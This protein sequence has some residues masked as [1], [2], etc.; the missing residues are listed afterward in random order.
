MKVISSIECEVN[1][2]RLK[3]YEET[4][5]LTPAQYKKRLDKITESAAQEYGFKVVQSANGK[6]QET[7]S[8]EQESEH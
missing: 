7:Q 3:I 6:S 2:I 4:K 1:E 5:N 8:A